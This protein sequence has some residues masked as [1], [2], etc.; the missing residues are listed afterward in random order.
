MG[1]TQQK[2]D[3]VS[4]NLEVSEFIWLKSM[5]AGRKFVEETEAETKA[6]EIIWEKLDKTKLYIPL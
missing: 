3:T 6:K 5:L 1:I 4:I 2:E